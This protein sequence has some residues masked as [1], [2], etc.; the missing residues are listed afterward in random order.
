MFNY[1]QKL[2]QLKDNYLSDKL[3]IIEGEDNKSLLAHRLLQ[4]GYLF[5]SSAK[6]LFS[7]PLFMFSG[8]VLSHHAVEL[9]LKA[10]WIWDKTSLAKYIT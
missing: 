9:T 3:I 8:A 10:C 6:T 2:F 5:F 4:D 1:L 7:H